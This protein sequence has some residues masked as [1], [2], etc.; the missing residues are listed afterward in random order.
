MNAINEKNVQK[1]LDFI[2]DFQRQEG[3]SPSFRQIKN[4]CGFPTLSTAQKYVA[5]LQKRNLIEKNEQGRIV[6][7]QNLS[8]GP[9]NVAPIVGNIACGLPILAEE[10]IE[11]TFQLP[12]QIFGNQKL[13]I[14]HACGDSMIGVGIN[15]GD[16]IVAEIC[17]TAE[18]GDIVVALL[19]DSATVKTFYKKKNH[20]VLHA[21]NPKYEDI[22]TKELVIQGVVK[23]V[24]HSF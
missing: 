5:L 21:E 9:S 14:L 4:G 19:G 7:P 10:N 12:T 17:N 6:I 23:H 15:D 2:K 8:I 11:G 1:V 24:I 20:F 22:I 18:N 13:M 3:R 16:L